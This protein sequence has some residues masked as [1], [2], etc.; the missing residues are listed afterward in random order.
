M[1]AFHAR[2]AVSEAG[3][4]LFSSYSLELW[5]MIFNFEPGLDSVKANQ[6]V[7]Y[8]SQRLSSSQVIVLIHRQTG[9]TKVI[10]ENIYVYF[11]SKKYWFLTGLRT[12][13]ICIVAS[14]KKVMFLSLFVCLSVCLSVSNFAQKL[15]NGFAWNFQGRLAM[16]ANEQLLRFWWRSGSPT[17]YRDCFFDSSL[18]GDTES[19]INRLR[20]A[21]LQCTACT[22]RHRHSNCDVITS[23]AHDR[24]RDWYRATG[25]TCLGG[26]KHCSSASSFVILVS[27]D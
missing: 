21:T 24:Q 14:A 23:P 6:K 4:T 25:N 10:V 13:R 12:C 7:K 3:E 19:G 17:G 8:L 20:C 5:P 16:G 26:G 18:L 2:S 27:V 15:S 1:S 11:L 22:S 9:G